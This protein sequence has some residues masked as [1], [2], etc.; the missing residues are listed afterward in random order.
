MNNG[1]L[2]FYKQRLKKC[3]MSIQNWVTWI[4]TLFIYLFAFKKAGI[5]SSLDYAYKIGILLISFF[6]A[7]LIVAFVAWLIKNN[8]V[9]KG[10]K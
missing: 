3:I 5:T 6:L 10:D 2:Q 8:K 9:N 4:I 1:F 7:N